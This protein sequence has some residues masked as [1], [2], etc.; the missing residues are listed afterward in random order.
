MSNKFITYISTLLILVFAIIACACSKKEY[1]T[2]NINI[3]RYDQAIFK[4]NQN[5]LAEDL[6]NLESK[7]PLFLSG[8]NLKDSSNIIRISNFINDP[9]IKES[10][11]KINEVFNDTLLLK[12]NLA[13]MYAKTK[14]IFPNFNNPTLYTYISY[15]DFAN[16][17]I[18]LDTAI[19]VALDMYLPNF[20]KHYTSVG[21]PMYLSKRASLDLF[22]VE[23]ARSIAINNIAYNKERVNLLE[24][25]V[26]QGKI[27]YVLENILPKEI[28]KPAMFSYNKEQYQWC[29]K[30]E[31]YL[32]LYILKNQYLYE[33][34][35]NKIKG[36]IN[37]G[38]YNPL[39]GQDS[40]PRTAQYIGY[41]MVQKYMEKTNKKPYELFSEEAQEV[42]NK[43]KYKP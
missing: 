21:L 34:E 36:F 17:I 30:N 7:Y 16:R 27:M 24:E 2:D 29:K 32:W 39:L 3:K 41:K 25:I 23:L 37:D 19:S 4:L 11:D 13:Y 43:S 20:E 12:E 33:T 31:G 22:Y 5:N 9:I 28:D 35:L 40:P 8:M 1:N 6:K 10:A 42:L 15:F 18:Y 14:E 38:P 26:Y